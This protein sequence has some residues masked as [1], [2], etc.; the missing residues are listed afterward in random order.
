MNSDLLS[1]W[2]FIRS[3]PAAAWL[4]RDPPQP[5]QQG[6]AGG[7]RSAPERREGRL[8][9][10][11]LGAL[12]LHSPEHELW[13]TEALIANLKLLKMQIPQPHL[14]LGVSAEVGLGDF[15]VFKKFPW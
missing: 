1:V 12:H 2:P 9:L 11:F 5:G 6:G 14:V 7:G 8:V 4:R 3:A 15:C 10:G 13:K